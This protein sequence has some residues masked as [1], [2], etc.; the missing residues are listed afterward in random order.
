MRSAFQNSMQATLPLHQPAM[1]SPKD[2]AQIAG[3]S[4][5]RQRVQRDSR[6]SGRARPSLREAEADTTES[7]LRRAWAANELAE[8]WLRPARSPY[9]R[10]S[11]CPEAEA[12]R[13]RLRCSA[14][15]VRLAQL[16]T[17]RWPASPRRLTHFVRR[18]QVE[19]AR[20]DRLR[21]PTAPAASRPTTSSRRWALRERLADVVRQPRLRSGRVTSRKTVRNASISDFLP[22]V[23]SHDGSA[24]GGIIDRP[25]L[26]ETSSVAISGTT[27]RF[28]SIMIKF[29]CDGIV[30]K[31]HLLEFAGGE[32][33]CFCVEPAPFRH[34][35]RDPRGSPSPRPEP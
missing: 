32:R 30:M 34:L 1:N 5:N 22:I 25:E 20:L 3:R 13:E 2:H 24:W 11:R 7:H 31:A 4:R 33:S 23:S 29:A 9:L 17:P 26:Y 15:K 6:L 10:H 14:V 21:F 27:G 28:T 19:Y 16:R 35:D 12:V 8:S 18:D